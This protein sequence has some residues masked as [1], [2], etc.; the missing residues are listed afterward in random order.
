M[1]PRAL[2][3]LFLLLLLTLTTRGKS[4]FSLSLYTKYTG[5]TLG[6]SHYLLRLNLEDAARQRDVGIT[7]DIYYIKSHEFLSTHALLH[8]TNL[9]F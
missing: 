6:Y 5:E 9:L 4:P 8:F 1:E 2:A 7:G 3:F